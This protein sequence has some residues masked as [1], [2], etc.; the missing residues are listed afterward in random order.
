MLPDPQ[1]VMVFQATL[2][3][4]PVDRIVLNL[5]GNIIQRPWKRA[6]SKAAIARR[7]NADTLRVSTQMKQRHTAQYWGWGVALIMIAVMIW[8]GLLVTIWFWRY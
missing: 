6:L 5:Q 2:D 8:V 7:L 1:E 3:K 4:T